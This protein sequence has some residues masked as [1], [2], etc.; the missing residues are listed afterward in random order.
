[1]NK[2]VGI[3]V[4]LNKKSY[5]TLSN[6]KKYKHPKFY[7]KS[8]RKLKEANRNLSRKMKGSQN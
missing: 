6:G 8:E 4:N 1:M 2:K 7:K 3:D 5:I